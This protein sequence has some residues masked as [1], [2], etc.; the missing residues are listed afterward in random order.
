[1]SRTSETPMSADS[2]A[3]SSE[4]R[5][6]CGKCLA[7]DG[8]I[9]CSRCN[10]LNS[11]P[12]PPTFREATAYYLAAKALSAR[13]L[14]HTEAPVKITVVPGSQ[15]AGYV[16][17]EPKDKS[18]L[19]TTEDMKRKLVVIMAGVA[20]ERLIGSKSPRDTANALTQAH[21]LAM[22]VCDLECAQGDRTR[23]ALSLVSEALLEAMSILGRYA[24]EHARLTD[25]LLEKGELTADDINSLTPVEPSTTGSA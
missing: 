14:D 3:D 7:K 21:D 2:S 5:C 11:L 1:M 23:R 16:Q 12:T 18:P 22:R 17:F 13:V 19:L 4:L 8:A 25:A 24:C 6:P 9:K 15:H 20:A 10:R